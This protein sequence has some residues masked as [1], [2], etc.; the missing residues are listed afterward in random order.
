MQRGGLATAGESGSG[1]EGESGRVGSTGVA[2]P[3]CLEGGSVTEEEGVGPRIWGLGPLHRTE[4]VS[5][6]EEEWGVGGGG[7][8]QV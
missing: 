2:E 4:V 3:P 5:Q 6:L 7:T 8:E 1:V